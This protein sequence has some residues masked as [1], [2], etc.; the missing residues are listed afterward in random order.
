VSVLRFASLA[1]YARLLGHV[2]A[3]FGPSSLGPAGLLA[4]AGVRFPVAQIVATL[5]GAAVLVVAARR[6]SFVLALT[7]SLLITPTVWLHYLTL[8]ALPLALYSKRLN[9]LWAATLLLWGC[10]H[11]ARG[12]ALDETALALAVV[13]AL[14]IRA[15]FGSG[16]IHRLRPALATGAA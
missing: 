6:R 14:T 7:A 3:T 8:L 11:S 2:A 1:W 12:G 15:E 16:A 9:M 13:A 5:A 10:Q 4:Q